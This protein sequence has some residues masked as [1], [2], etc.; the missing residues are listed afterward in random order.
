MTGFW[1]IAPCS[2]VDVDRRFR[3]AYCPLHQGSSPWDYTAQYPRRLSSSYSSRWEPNISPNIVMSNAARCGASGESRL[4]HHAGCS[5]LHTHQKLWQKN[6]KQWWNYVLTGKNWNTREKKN[7]LQCHFVRLIFHIY[8]N[9]IKAVT[10]RSE[11]VNWPNHLFNWCKIIWS[12][13]T[14]RFIGIITKPGLWIL[15]QF[16]PVHIFKFIFVSW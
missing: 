10:P 9:G 3:G 16:N 12:Y 14:Q 11:T 6:M 7:V 5:D 4:S 2:L 1:D 15:R 13:A 8:C